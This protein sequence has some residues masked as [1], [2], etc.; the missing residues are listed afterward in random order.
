MKRRDFLR[1]AM[2]TA[3]AA[4]AAGV[5]SKTVTGH[6][7][8]SPSP[9]L[10]TGVLASKESVPAL[11]TVVL[12]ANYGTT[13]TLKAG[14]HSHK[15]Q[16]PDDLPITPMYTDFPPLSILGLGKTVAEVEAIGY[17]A[18]QIDA[19]TDLCISGAIMQRIQ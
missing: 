10:S 3:A 4:A 8:A 16:L 5:A 12:S 19:M 2:V 11:S 15:W 6:G 9:A 7:P 1:R 18:E 17:S 13:Y 14:E